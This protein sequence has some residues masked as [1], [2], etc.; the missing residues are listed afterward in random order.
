M[1]TKLNRT[2]TVAVVGFARAEPQEVDRPLRRRRLMRATL[3]GAM[4]VPILGRAATAQELHVDGSQS[5]VVRFVSRTPVHHFEG[6]TEKIVGYVVLDGRGL[7]AANPSETE[8]YFEVDLASIDTGIGLRNRHMRENYLEV[9]KYPYASFSGRIAGAQTGAGAAR[10]TAVGIFTVHGVSKQREI[11][12][13]VTERGGGYRADCAFM[14]ELSEH[15]IEVPSVM[16]VRVANQIEV[17]VEF[18]VS[19]AHDRPD[20]RP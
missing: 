7:S 8:I 19:P 16:F 13:R 18:T 4:L 20:E 10:V 12:C 9:E 1:K 17:R 3:I 2:N 6:V 11:A 14:V 15:A 5:P